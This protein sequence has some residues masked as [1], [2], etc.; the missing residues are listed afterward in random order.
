MPPTPSPVVVAI[1]APLV[2]WRF[3]S[4]FK[5]LTTRQ[6]SRTWR[7]RTTL[8][9]FPLLLLM[10]GL[11]SMAAPWA[12]VALACG[13]GLGG[14]LGR[15]AISKTKFEKV[16]DDEFYFTPHG[17]IGMAVA[18]LFFGRL[19]YRAW[20]FYAHGAASHHEFVRSPLTMLIF[21]IM[22]GYYMLYA[23]GLLSWRKR[24][25]NQLTHAS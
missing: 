5:R 8:V 1:L 15:L 4:R 9:F 13:L 24:A 14:T 10:V 17:P 6:R 2:M 25:A 11:A 7:H 22:A 12:L 19:G 23:V 16:G 21:G 20:E 3:Y 18:A